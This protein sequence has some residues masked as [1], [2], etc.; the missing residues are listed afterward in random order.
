M[1]PVK[2][3]KTLPNIEISNESK[4]FKEPD[5]YLAAILGGRDKNFANCRR[6]PGGRSLAENE[7]V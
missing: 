2:F 4:P 6:L 7:M 1:N 3:M 5:E